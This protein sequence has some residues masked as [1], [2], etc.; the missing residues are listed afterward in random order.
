MRVDIQQDENLTEVEI[1][2]RCRQIDDEVMRLVSMLRAG[3]RKMVAYGRGETVLLA[4]DEI[5][6][7]E[8]VD[9]KTFAYTDN[10]VL[11][12]PLRLYELEERFGGHGFLRASKSMV[13]NLNRVSSLRPYFGGKIELCMANKERIYVSRQ[14]VAVLKSKLGI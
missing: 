7:F 3:E 11:E 10:S 8:S 13:F 1:L 6:Y 5:L 9:K 14:Y 2:V 12:T 4:V